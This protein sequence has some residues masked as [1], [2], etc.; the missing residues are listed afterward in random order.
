MEMSIFKT[1]NSFAKA[2]SLK[3]LQ[4]VIFNYENIYKNIHFLRKTRLKMF[5]KLFEHSTSVSGLHQYYYECKEV[6]EMTNTKNIRSND[7]VNNLLASLEGLKRVQ[8]DERVEFNILRHQQ[9]NSVL[10]S[11]A[12]AQH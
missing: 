10:I 9:T 7:M 11:M 1:M 4:N 3:N 12:S 8:R 5:K 2:K 6:S